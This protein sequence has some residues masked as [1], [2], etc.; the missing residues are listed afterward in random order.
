MKAVLNNTI[1][2]LWE[3]GTQTVPAWWEKKSIL[4]SGVSR[5]V[6]CCEGIVELVAKELSQDLKAKN[7]GSSAMSHKVM[8]LSW[9]KAS[10]VIKCCM[11][12]W[13]LTCCK[14]Y[15][16]KNQNKPQHIYSG[17]KTNIYEACQEKS[18][19]FH[20]QK[21]WEIIYFSHFK[22]IECLEFWQ[23]LC[24][25]SLKT[26]LRDGLSPCSRCICIE[27]NLRAF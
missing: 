26:W 15:C 14:K 9:A 13:A 25:S 19:V 6:Q 27:K 24:F 17:K 23:T 11:S 1:H 5:T 10:V 21:W 3:P 20:T 2:G 22:D 7:C 16:C 8:S 4:K 12:L 18:M